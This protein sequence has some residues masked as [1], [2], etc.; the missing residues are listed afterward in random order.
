MYPLELILQFPPM[1]EFAMEVTTI[2]VLLNQLKHIWN[3][4]TTHSYYMSKT[5]FLAL[6]SEF[7]ASDEY[8][9]KQ[10]R[11][12]KRLIFRHHVILFQDDVHNFVPR[13][14]VIFNSLSS[15]VNLFCLPI[16]YCRI[17]IAENN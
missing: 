8:L 17:N 9:K 5:T 11:K 13:H 14:F 2:L 10:R 16:S 6:V 3:L 12:K 1:K 4:I 15:A 7:Y